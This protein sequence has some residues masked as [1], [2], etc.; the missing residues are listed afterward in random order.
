MSDPNEPPTS[1]KLEK[2]GP[3][4]DSALP[5]VDG[6]TPLDSAVLER[7]AIRQIGPYQ[8]IKKLG[9]GGMGQV[10]LAQQSTP[11]RRQVALKLIR[12]GLYDDS[13]LQRF[14]S[15][16]Q[17]LAIMDHPAIAKVFAAGT[18]SD[19][20]PY[21]VMEYVQG[22]P[23]TEYCDGKRLKI[24][25]RLELFI[26]V[27]E[28][29]QHAHQ[30][31]IIHRDLK[32]ANILVVDVDGRPT[33]RIIDFGLAK[34]TSPQIAEATLITQFGGFV[35]TP[36]FMSPEQADP[37]VRDVD[38]RTDVYSLGVVL[39]VLL[40]GFLPFDAEKWKK[41]SIFEIVRQLHRDD[42][43]RP[44]AK[45]KMEPK[46]SIT[47][48]RMRTVTAHQ[49]GGL[50]RGDLDWITMKA[51]EKDPSRRYGTP[52]EL[53]ADIQR[54]MKLE[55]VVARAASAGYRF[56]KY[57]RRHK[58]GVSVATGL[59]L[60]LAGFAGVQAA[61][62]R[63]I[64]RERDRANR[65]TD[66]MTA[67][68]HVSNP[69]EARGN[70]IT[71]REILD[72]ASSGVDIGLAKD[73]VLQ[74]QMMYV[75]GT[76]Y[77]NLGLYP[78]S[79][80]LL[81][82]AV[83]IQRRELGPYDPETLKSMNA[84][85]VALY[86]GGQIGAA[87]KLGREGFESAQRAF[88]QKDSRT[89]GWAFNVAMSL[90][91]EGRYAEAEKLIRETLA[92][93]ELTL[94]PDNHD[95]WRYRIGLAIVLSDRGQFAEAEK[96]WRENLEILRRTLGPEDPETL[97]VM[98][99]VAVAV[100]NQGRYGEAEKMQREALAAERRVLGSEHPA[101]MF[102]MG[103]LADTLSEEGR[104]DEAE[105]LELEAIDLERRV[106][107]AENPDVARSVYN[108]A[109]IKARQGRRDEAFAFLSQSIDHNLPAGTMM[110]I[111]KDEDLKSLRGDPRFDAI[112]LKAKELAASSPKPQ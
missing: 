59:A 5:T 101:T 108:L 107:G 76:V 30:K 74:A 82:Q 10:W 64:T 67:M 85:A 57:V 63:R 81:E 88:G 65:I 100:S 61:Q 94:G 1:D 37:S 25:E 62:V 71:A 8:L 98:D 3:A 95:T 48:A 104:L 93:A 31:A 91:A 47:N 51:L 4:I 112:V 35:G 110:G 58:V 42:P 19:G 105:K 73:P 39:Y 21:F 55:P 78:H 89:L 11:V 32:P 72:K 2:S 60:I 41:Q 15:E 26:K 38:T 34:A 36:G 49:L 66:F 29:V 90:Q 28:G 7:V 43:P 9:E 52:S 17:S 12:V 75:M 40:T 70:T 69:S 84:L 23:I 54:Y 44:S 111:A 103:N 13:V 16:R 86:Q 20:Q 80:S 96:I 53:A 6:N 77:T 27:C 106:L 68:F 22:L 99:N 102:T 109:C 33:P 45:I 18:T 50:L 56:E 24:R 83:R 14:Q 79:Q 97:Q 92:K 46:S 87:E